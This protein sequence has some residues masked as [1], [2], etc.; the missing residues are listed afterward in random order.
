MQHD[1]VK[2]KLMTVYDEVFKHDGFGSFTLS[3]KILKKH[4]KEVI[5][6]CGKQYRYVV[7]RRVKNAEPSF[8]LKRRNTDIDA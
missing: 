3:M 2:E 7:D 5:I 4:Q 6:D 8:A 1:E